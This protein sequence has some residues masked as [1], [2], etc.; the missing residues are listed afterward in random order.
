MPASCSGGVD[1]LSELAELDAEHPLWWTPAERLPPQ[2]RRT[3]PSGAWNLGVAH[4]TPG[5]I[6]LL[7]KAHAAGVVTPSAPGA[8]GGVAAGAAHAVCSW[9]GVSRVRGTGRQ[10]PRGSRLAWCYG[11]L[12]FAGALSVAGRQAGELEWQAPRSRWPNTPRRDRGDERSD[13][14]H[15]CHGSAGVAHIFNR[16]FQSSGCECLR[17]TASSW[18]ESAIE[19]VGAERSRGRPGPAHGLRRRRPGAAGSHYAGRA[20]LGPPAATVLTYA[21]NGGGRRRTQSLACS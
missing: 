20:E 4:G 9:H 12:G 14:A 2:I 16:L 11:D 19:L 18:L 7:A 1:R 15:I 8:R 17:T 3:F 21:N 13:E 5:V 10:L 6:A